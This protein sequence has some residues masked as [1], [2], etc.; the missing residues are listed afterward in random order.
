MK[1]E[2][3]QPYSHPDY[4]PPAGEDLAAI[5][6]LLG[7]SS[8]DTAQ[9]VGVASGRTVRKWKAGSAPIPYGVWRLLLLEVFWQSES[10]D[11][12]LADVVIDALAN[13]A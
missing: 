7:L 3:L 11:D 2:S 10:G 1:K 6:D 12:D 9:L 13:R 8:F 4:Q 5:M